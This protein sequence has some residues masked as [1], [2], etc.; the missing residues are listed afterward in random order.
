M[1]TIKAFYDKIKII[2]GLNYGK[3][4]TQK[5]VRRKEKHHNSFIKRVRY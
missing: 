5:N 4:K 1:V 2:G 3:K